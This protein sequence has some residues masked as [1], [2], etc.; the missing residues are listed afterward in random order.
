M[1][2]S[3]SEDYGSDIDPDVIKSADSEDSLL[4]AIRSG[5]LHENRYN[6]ELD[7]CRTEDKVLR[8]LQVAVKWGHLDDCKHIVQFWRT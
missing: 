7:R 8:L 4:L 3:S 1:S 2:S 6:P 5:R